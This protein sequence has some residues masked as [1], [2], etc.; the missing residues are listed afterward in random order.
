MT[1]F[2]KT[3]RTKRRTVSVFQ[4]VWLKSSHSQHE[5]GEDFLPE[6]RF[7]KALYLER[8]RAE[9]SRKLFLLVLLSNDERSAHSTDGSFVQGIK[10]VFSTLATSIRE[11]DLWGW[12]E[13][14]ATAG[15]IF[16]EFNGTEKP[17]ILATVSEKLDQALRAVLPDEHMQQLR[18]SFHFFPEDWTDRDRPQTQEMFYPNAD[19]LG[20]S[21]QLS[22]AIKRFIDVAGS[23]TMLALLSP[24]FAAIAL[25]IKL[26][27]R[28]PV[29]FK[30]ERVGQ[31]GMRFFCLKFR[32]MAVENNPDVHQE[33]IRRFIAGEA[34]TEQSDEKGKRVFK[35]ARDKRV[36]RIGS[37]LRKTSIDEL[38]QLFNVLNGEMS[39]VGPRPPVPY[40]LQ[41]YHVW[42]VR[43]IF[44][45]KP[46]ITGLWQ[47]MGRSRTTFD[48]MVRLDLRYAR[49]WSLWLDLKILARTPHAVFSGN[50]AY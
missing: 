38:P 11:T 36:T 20:K 23:L 8:C 4:R 16:T 43:R 22:R 5:D 6:G 27:S 14:N 24:L 41:S 18:L 29:I 25:A 31:F 12:Y 2:L 13:D 7:R 10:Q 37:W 45:A 15:I 40:E 44:E 42:H 28:G 21:A 47:V 48:E 34:G 1:L 3:T 9:R 30:Q 17:V 26:D 49:T 46:G 33:Y 19:G 35:I 39:L 50:G 32:S